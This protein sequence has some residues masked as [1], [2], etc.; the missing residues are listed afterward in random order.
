V[1]PLESSRRNACTLRLKNTSTSASCSFD[2]HG[3]IL[4]IFGK[5]QSISTAHFLNEKKNRQVKQKKL[6]LLITVEKE[7]LLYGSLFRFIKF[8][9]FY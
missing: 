7:H 9:L 3:L 4:T 1:K 5:Q 8:T 2:K 6:I